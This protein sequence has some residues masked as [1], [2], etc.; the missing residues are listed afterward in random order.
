ME[1]I[2]G[3][4]QLKAIQSGHPAQ[5]FW[6]SAKLRLIDR[7]NL[8]GDNKS[9]IDIG[10]GS[11]V[12]SEY[13]STSCHKVVGVDASSAAIM[14]AQRQ[15]KKENLTF[16]NLKIDDLDQV[17]EFDLLLC[18]E[19]LE[20]LHKVDVQRAM[21]K[22]STIAKPDARLVITVPNNRSLWPLIEKLLDFFK[23][24]PTLKDEQHLSTFNKRELVNG[25]ERSGWKVEKIGTFNGVAPFA[26]VI[27]IKLGYVLE[28]V[29][30]RSG[31][32]IPNNLIYCV[33][34]KDAEHFN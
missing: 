19:V 7:L 31:N 12:A 4:Y 18:F 14:F 6:H 17:E 9:V 22:F 11:G 33:A 13:L 1:E 8:V 28:R 15:F 25:L 2:P 5:R 21:S 24:V 30:F 3:D 34:Y 23:M 26:S 10:C 20:H 29:E 27:S 32:F 16:R